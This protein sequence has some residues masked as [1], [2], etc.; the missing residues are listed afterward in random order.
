MMSLFKGKTT[1]KVMYPNKAI[2]YR[3]SLQPTY[4]TFATNSM[5]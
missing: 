5:I 1:L 2:H 3:R 4:K